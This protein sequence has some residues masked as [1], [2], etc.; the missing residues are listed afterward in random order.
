MSLILLLLSSSLFGSYKVDSPIGWLIKNSF[1]KNS[2][3]K[4]ITY[5]K[6][7]AY[8]KV[9]PSSWCVIFFVV[10]LFFRFSFIYLWPSKMTSAFILFV[11]TSSGIDPE[12]I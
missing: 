9:D 8:S 4:K 12:L 5:I 2:F 3:R 10:V 6:K 1:T 7:I 11:L